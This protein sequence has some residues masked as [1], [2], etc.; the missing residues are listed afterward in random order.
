MDLTIRSS[1]CRKLSLA[2]R[3][4]LSLPRGLDLR[5]ALSVRGDLGLPLRCELSLMRGLGCVGAGAERAGLAGRRTR[6]PGRRYRRPVFTRRLAGRPSRRWWRPW[7]LEG[8]TGRRIWDRRWG[9][10]RGRRWR[11]R[12]WLRSRSGAEG[13]ATRVLRLGQCASRDGAVLRL[14]GRLPLPCCKLR[15]IDLFCE[16]RGLGVTPILL[17]VPSGLLLLFVGSMVGLP[18]LVCLL[19]SLPLGTL[20][21]DLAAAR[22]P[23]RFGDRLALFPLRGVIDCN[24]PGQETAGQISATV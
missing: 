2:L 12:L 15:V 6:T 14:L 18:F 16:T 19:I 11:L 9:S 8:R 23:V 4:E 7:G 3:F 22:L 13:P 10:R 1:L 5:L 17:G 20:G 24:G 21:I